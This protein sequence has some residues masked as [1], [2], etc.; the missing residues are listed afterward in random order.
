MDTTRE[1]VVSWS[2]EILVFQLFVSI[3]NRPQSRIDVSL[4]DGALLVL[5]PAGGEAVSQFKYLLYSTRCS[6]DL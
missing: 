3:M 2:L 5:S 1:L 4:L 6:P